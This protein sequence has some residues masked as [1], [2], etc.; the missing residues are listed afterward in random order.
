[1]T[2]STTATKFIVPPPFDSESAGD[3]I[4]R[5]PDGTEFKV[6]KA[7]LYV[8]S[9]IFRDMFDMPPAAQEN[10]DEAIMPTISVEEDPETMQTLLQMLYPVEPPSVKSLSLAWKLV[11]ACDKY[12]VNNEK[13]RLHLK[14][15]LRNSQSLKED[16]LTCY[17]LSWRLGLEEEVIAASRYTHSVDLSNNAVAQKIVST[18]GS[19]EAFAR[20]WDLKFRREKA[21]DRILA[22]AQTKINRDMA[23]RN[24]PT[25]TGSAKDHSTRK[26]D[27]RLALLVPSP[28]CSDVEIFLGFQAGKGN[29]TCSDC[30][31]KR[32]HILEEFRGEV[33]EAL[34]TYPQAIQGYVTPSFCSMRRKDTN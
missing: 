5:A 3:C 13:V 1:M 20:L 21:L 27:L 17:S 19:L 6:F 7:I 30:R 24:H 22:L 14:E 23:C 12:F 32:S 4:L 31:Y 11:T 2:E 29:P 18:S 15:T 33:N 16:P 8:G 34:T 10:K 26:D 9:T 25:A 28:V